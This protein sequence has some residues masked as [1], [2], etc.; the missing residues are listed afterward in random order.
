MQ[1]GEPRFCVWAGRY[2]CT[3]GFVVSLALWQRQLRFG[4]SAIR[5]RRLKFA[6]LR[7]LFLF[8][9]TH[10]V[11]SHATYCANWRRGALVC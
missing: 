3:I 2:G 4:E 5:R 11:P 7:A 10:F 9:R 1:Q 8:G 6:L